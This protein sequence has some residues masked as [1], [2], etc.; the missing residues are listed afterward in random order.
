MEKGGGDCIYCVFY[1]SV[2]YY[3]LI[4]NEQATAARAAQYWKETALGYFG[5]P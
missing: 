4:V 3:L 1:S 2:F 5:F